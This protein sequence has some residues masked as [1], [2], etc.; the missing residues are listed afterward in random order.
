[1]VDAEGWFDTGDVATIDEHGF[2]LI[3]D[4]TK[5]LIRSGGEW[6]SSQALE[7]AAASTPGVVAC[8]AIAVP[9]E[10]WGERPLL[11]VQCSEGCRVDTA[12]LLATMS[13]SVPKWCASQAMHMIQHATSTSERRLCACPPTLSGHRLWTG[14]AAP[15]KQ[16]RRATA[17][18]LRCYAST[19][20]LLQPRVLVP[21]S[22]V[23]Y[24]LC[25]T[26]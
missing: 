23:C 6:I 22:P 5:D 21:K 4:R 19:T 16:G 3:V 14:P 24:T 25:R 9:S 20:C 1:M 26:R 18:P 12:A 11:L 15:W 2:M 10:R 17:C 7:G 13:E 8:A